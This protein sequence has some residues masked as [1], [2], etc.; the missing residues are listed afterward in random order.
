M[1]I[2]YLLEGEPDGSG[3]ISSDQPVIEEAASPPVSDASTDT[4][5]EAVE[6]AAE[7]Q[8]AP[9]ADSDAPADLSD[10]EITALADLYGDKL[11]ASE[12]VQAEI[13][14][15]A[16]E[17]VE[18]EKQA[19][20]NKPEADPFYRAISAESQQAY[21][22]IAAAQQKMAQGEYPDDPESLM[23]AIDTTGSWQA[24]SERRGQNLAMRMT[25]ERTLGI[26]PNKLDDS[27]PIE[28][29]YADMLTSLETGTQNA[30]RLRQQ[31]VREYDPQKRAS[32]LARSEQMDAG[33]NGA[34]IFEGIKLAVAHG[35][36]LEAVDAEKR[37]GKRLADTAK[38]ERSNG[39]TEAIA[40]ARAMLAGAGVNAP[41]P[42]KAPS[43]GPLTVEEAQTLPIEEL[44]RRSKAQ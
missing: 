2:R 22:I 14:R 21:Q 3:T 20:A 24:A 35:R 5:Q 13:S 4:P 16:K 37:T 7:A 23:A 27:K 42:T 12:K 15:R 36:A 25:L 26:D 33:A 31:A 34:S 32:L 1:H 40:K 29:A 18:A 39:N 28:K 30:Y 6:P 19:T 43:T 17:T 11:L 44:I 41:V 8:E 10:D 9:A 38:T